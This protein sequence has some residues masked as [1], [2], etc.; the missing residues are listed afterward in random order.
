M[1]VISL[2]INDYKKAINSVYKDEN[3]KKKA[4][5]TINSHSRKKA[6]SFGKL[7]ACAASVIICAAAVIT[8]V[9][10]NVQNLPS[11]SGVVQTATTSEP[12]NSNIDELSSNFAKGNIRVEDGIF[13][14]IDVYL[15][16]I[17]EDEKGYIGSLVSASA[18]YDT[19][20]WNYEDFGGTET[21][22]DYIG[23]EIYIDYNNEYI[24]LLHNG[25]YE[26]FV[27][28]SDT[29]VYEEDVR[30][31]V[32]MYRYTNK[33]DITMLNAYEFYDKD[34][35]YVSSFLNN[36]N[37]T[38][39]NVSDFN[40][41]VVL[42]NFDSKGNEKKEIT[43]YNKCDFSGDDNIYGNELIERY[44]NS[45]NLFS[46]VNYNMLYE[47]CSNK[48]Q[49][50]TYNDY[51]EAIEIF[52]AEDSETVKRAIITD[53]TEIENF[54]N[55]LDN[56]NTE[57][58][59]DSKAYIV[60]LRYVDTEINYAYNNYFENI[61]YGN[62]IFLSET[63]Y[64]GNSEIEKIFNSLPSYD[65]G[66]YDY[67]FVVNGTATEYLDTFTSVKK[68]LDFFMAGTTQKMANY[69]G[70]FDLNCY[71]EFKGVKLGGY[72]LNKAEN[73]NNEIIVDLYITESTNPK[74]PVGKSTWVADGPD[75]VVAMVSR[76]R[77]IENP[78]PNYKVEEI[79]KFCI[80]FS[81][82][83]DAFESTTDL[84]IFAKDNYHGLAHTVFTENPYESIFSLSKDEFMAY[85]NER[86]GITDVDMTKYD[87]YDESTDVISECSGHGGIWYYYD[88]VS[89]TKNTDGTYT[90]S[91]DYYADACML[92]LS[93]TIQYT[94]I[95][96]NNEYKYR[97]SEIKCVYDSGYLPRS[98]AI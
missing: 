58:S 1:E 95:P 81:T 13:S 72:A 59:S 20:Y 21:L 76:F 53:K 18:T 50:E 28:I 82:W 66:E 71:D 2:K 69:A 90:V 7:V 97:I 27:Y 43:F 74:F 96:L 65:C 19:E 35:E 78:V 17:Q 29:E 87:L 91:V 94:V 92:V 88:N 36:F 83:L 55:N 47:E 68:F 80:N 79:S 41:I 12:E 30:N 8:T 6:S 38:Q 25:I 77:P 98:G 34:Y 40:Y 14:N 16:E 75:G 85:L 44:W 61:Y 5:E 86:Y 62:D 4:V 39:N 64:Y 31:D 3:L 52:C 15:P 60:S 93:K 63:D 37:E 26:P 48:Y 70:A 67:N 33:D 42:S 32:T 46:C 10:Y 56:I 11:Q 89:T 22:S 45:K 84:N 57:Q 49:M 73:S 54:I 9:V 51:V 23:C 24:Y